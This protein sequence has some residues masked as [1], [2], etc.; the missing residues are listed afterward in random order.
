MFWNLFAILFF[1][2]A[3]GGLGDRPAAG[4]VF[5]WSVFMTEPLKPPDIPERATQ[6]TTRPMTV[7]L[8]EFVLMPELYCP[9]DP[10]ELTDDTRQETLMNSLTVEGQLSA[11]E[12][13]RRDDGKP[14]PTR[15]HRRITAMRRLAERNTPGF[16]P[17]MPVQAIEVLGATPQ[18][19]LCRAVADNNRNNYTVIERIRA[20]KTLHDG[21]VETKRAAYALIISEKQYLRDLRIAQCPSMFDYVVAED[22]GATQASELLEAAEIFGRIPQLLEHFDKWVEETK[23]QIRHR[24]SREGKAGKTV[25]IKAALTKPLV[26]HWIDLLRGNQPLDDRLSAPSEAGIVNID[27][28]HN[29]VTFKETAIDLLKVPLPVLATRLAELKSSAQVML[30]YLK[31]RFVVEGSE[32]PQAMAREE[33]HQLDLSFLRDEGLDELADSLS[34]DVPLQQD[35]PEKTGPR[36]RKASR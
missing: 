24:A 25:K 4:P 15:G 31:K 3:A 26:D 6:A 17:K 13:F 14:V 1:G 27:P 22:I 32:G 12:F 28:D 19:L 30:G 34:H 35:S 2:L 11:V 21:G 20:A 7:P 9:R 29:T 33:G 8:D 36:P 5:E 10:L 16:T 23:K 18:D